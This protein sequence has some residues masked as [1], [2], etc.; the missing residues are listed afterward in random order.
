MTPMQKVR[1]RLLIR[2]PFFGTLLLS[3]PMVETRDV[4]TAATDMKRIYWNP[5]FF[6]TLTVDEIEFVVMHELMHI[7]HLHGLRRQG[8]NPDRWNIACDYAIN[9]ALK[10]G[11]RHMPAM[12]L[13]NSE[14]AGL[15]ADA[16]YEKMPADDDP[17]SSLG[18]DLIPPP[19]GEDPA[20]VAADV[21]GRVAQAATA[22]RLQGA[23]P[24]DIARIVDD[25]VHHQVPWRDLLRHYMV[26]KART[27]QNWAKR[28]RRFTTVILPSRVG[29]RMRKI[30]L[31]VDTSGSIS[32][33][34][35]T[36]VASEV[37]AIGDE[38]GA[39]D[40]HVK[41]ATTQTVHEQ[42]FG[43]GEPL[44]LEP[45]GGGG[46]DMRVPL[47]EFADDPPDVC[48]LL[49]DGYTPWPEAEPPYPLIVCCTTDV[50][51]PVGATVRVH[52]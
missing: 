10:A 34:I 40:T 7:I 46:T 28:N 52:V 48:V 32:P 2:S 49:T 17:Q 11:G 23:L 30:G 26:A 16:I 6:A 41:F 18:G 31:I 25:L 45:R 33:A 1:A 21:K 35:L 43:E 15:S 27:R 9:A 19:P 4:P 5:D 22:A 14:Y 38:A 51:A 13:F 39:Q 42:H 24:E 50:V 29:R 44:V 20:A 8:R 3:T 37:N 36:V 47:S 12:G